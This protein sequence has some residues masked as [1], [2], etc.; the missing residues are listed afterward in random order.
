MPTPDIDPAAFHDFEHTGWQRAAEHYGDAFGALT[1]QTAGPLLEAAGVVSGTRLL[2]VATGPGFIAA[3]A[4]AL[5]AEVIGLDFSAAMIADA[6]RRQAPAITFREGDAEAL[7]FEDASFDAVVMNFGLLHLARPDTAIAEA[8]RVLRP[9]GRYAFT[10]WAVPELAV[11]FGMAQRALQALGRLDVPLPEGPPF[12]RFS[13]AKEC[14]RTL[15]GIGFSAVE[16]TTLALEWRLTSADAVFDALSR[17]GV[18][19]AAVL[20]AQ[21]PEALAAIR[22]AIRREVESYKRGDQFILPMPAVLA[23]ATRLG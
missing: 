9:G 6:R 1:V 5:G 20:R 10:I 16:V 21:T 4:S 17:G 15:E 12:F 19:T 13:D 3:A 22:D 8:R 7:P 11:A 2:D 18:R 23:S 14:R